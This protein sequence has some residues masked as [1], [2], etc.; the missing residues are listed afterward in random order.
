MNCLDL[1]ELE[2]QRDGN[3]RWSAEAVGGGV[4]AEVPADR[5]TVE[6]SHSSRYPLQSR[7]SMRHRAN[8]E[9]MSHPV[10][11]GKPIAPKNNMVGSEVNRVW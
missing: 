4:Q 7:R 2:E 5:A 11:C 3:P 1:K 8:L 9:E 6:W 10:P